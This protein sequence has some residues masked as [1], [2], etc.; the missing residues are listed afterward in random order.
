MINVSQRSK[1]V[2]ATRLTCITKRVLAL[3]EVAY[4]QHKECQHI[5]KPLYPP[6]Q[7]ILVVDD[8][9][10]FDYLAGLQQ[11]L[12]CIVSIELF[13]FG[14]LALQN[15]QVYMYRSFLFPYSCSQLTCIVLCN[16]Y[17]VQSISE[18]FITIMWL[19][20]SSPVYS[21]YKYI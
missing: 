1:E 2:N 10:C 5:L 4:I 13:Y 16:A 3:I 11:Q 6:F 14:C 12:A 18:F 20:S 8:D 9:N 19:N 21:T 17:I 7:N 15:I